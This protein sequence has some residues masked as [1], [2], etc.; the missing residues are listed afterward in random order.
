MFI[1]FF[2]HRVNK[3]HSDKENNV[4]I[5]NIIVKILIV[6]LWLNF[7]LTSGISTI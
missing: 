1:L 7:F 6:I 3:E 4:T 5:T 2:I